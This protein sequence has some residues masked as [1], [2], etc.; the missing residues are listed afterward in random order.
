MESLRTMAGSTPLFWSITTAGLVA[1]AVQ[2][3]VMRAALVRRARQRRLRLLAEAG[4]WATVGAAPVPRRRLEL[5][6]LVALLAVPAATVAAVGQARGLVER[7]RAE[8]DPRTRA[9]LLAEGWNGQLQAISLGVVLEELAGGLGVLSISLALAARRQIAG[10]V[11]GAAVA[12]R[13]PAEAAAW[14]LFPTP[15]TETVVACAGSFAALGMLPALQG[16][17]SY[18]G[19]LGTRLA[20]LAGADPAER[21]RQMD[22]ILLEARGALEAG[23]SAGQLG[24]AL[25]AATCG[26]LLWWR[27]PARARRQWLARAAE[28]R[29]GP[30]GGAA[31]AATVA[32][33]LVA[34]ALYLVSRPLQ[35]END[36]PWPPLAGEGEPVTTAVETPDLAG[37]DRLPRA[38]VLEVSGRSARLDGE[39]VDPETCRA[40]LAPPASA[41]GQPSSDGVVL[42]CEAGAPAP[43]LGPFLAAARRSGVRWATFAFVGRETLSRPLLGALS[44]PRYTGARA[45]LEEDGAPGDPDA[46]AVRPGDFATCADLAARIVDLRRRGADVALAITP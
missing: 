1:F 4:D 45:R 37:P 5:V 3:L 41:G 30:K 42:V 24:L 6:A 40:R 20:A 36:V 44:R 31:W 15:E 19:I 22:A 7:S 8:Q 23:T 34:V 32:C 21:L 35:A 14:A 18:C 11:H 17:A 29:G 25:A 9:R 46:T 39:E 12:R 38:P 13:D 43:R 10:L 26:G 33:V 2:V 27:S 16:A 28:A